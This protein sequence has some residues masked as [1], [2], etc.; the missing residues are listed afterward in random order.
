MGEPRSFCKLLLNFTLNLSRVC[1]NTYQ[2]SKWDTFLNNNSPK[3]HKQNTHQQ[4]IKA[5]QKKEEK[6]QKKPEDQQAKQQETE[7]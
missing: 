7:P 3:Q 4:Q 5:E 1:Y 6:K 2:Y